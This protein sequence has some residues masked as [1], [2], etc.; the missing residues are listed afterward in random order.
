MRARTDDELLAA[1]PRDPSAFGEF[2]ERHA[3]PLTGYFLRRTRNPE[4]AADLTAETFADAL[5][6]A[7]RFDP[8]K[9]TAVMWLYGIAGRELADALEHG[10]VAT[11]ARRRMRI[12]RI[13]L[14][15]DALERVVEVASSAATGR[16]LAELLDELPAEQ[17]D[18]VR[19]RVLDELDYDEI[20]AGG[21]I[22][23]AVA[24]KRVSRGL[25][26]IRARMREERQP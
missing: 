13:E 25:A 16:R 21:A 5:M 8:A 18:A 4:W 11:R 26:G 19:A 14:D 17:R 20:A 22:S 7:R 6:R 23:E 10:A 3:V 2:Y 24:R 15:D 1:T 9:G 12:P